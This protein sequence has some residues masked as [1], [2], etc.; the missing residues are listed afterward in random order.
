MAHK[1]GAHEGFVG[2]DRCKVLIATTAALVAA[3]EDR[4]PI[5]P[6]HHA[7]QFAESAVQSGADEVKWRLH[8][9][10]MP[11]AFDITK[12]RFQLIVPKNYRADEPR[13]LF[14]WIS[15]SNTP[16][17]T[18]AWEAVL[19]SRKLL[20]AGALQSGNRRDIFARIRMAIDASVGMR[21]QYRID[22]RRV[23]VSGFSGGARVASML[24]VAFADVFT[25]TMPFM[26]VSFY[27]LACAPWKAVR[28]R[29]HPRRPGAR[30]REEEMPLRACDRRKGFQP[31]R[32][33][34][35]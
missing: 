21:R 23:Y 7:I 16:N 12:E 25:G 19:A 34:G 1:E 26:G 18:P 5:V 8:S 2:L 31:R 28:R 3:G 20:F 27:G 10:E 9:V 35:G 29:L 11:G 15:A 17:I 32:D 6:G 14:I 33:A 13:G 30:D 4:L 24:G 22:E